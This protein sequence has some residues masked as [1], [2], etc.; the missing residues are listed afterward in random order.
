MSQRDERQKAIEQ[1]RKLRD[2][3]N[4][5]GS[6]EAEI[7]FSMRRMGQLMDTFD[8]TMDEVSLAAEECKS[9]E[10]SH[11]LGSVFHLGTVAVAVAKFCD[12][13]VFRREGSKVQKRDRNGNLVYGKDARGRMRPHFEKPVYT[14]VFHGIESDAETA[15][16]LME[17]IRNSVVKML[18]DY[19]KTGEYKGYDGSKTV[20]TKSFVDGFA[21]RIVRRLE[22]LK[23][24][25]EE[26]IERARQAR[27]EDGEDQRSLDAEAAAH[28]RR[29]GNSTDLVALKDQKVKDSFKAKYGWTVKYRTG[30]RSGG[31]S[32]T[33]RA[34]GHSAANNVNLSRPIGNGGG[35]S[36]QR[37]L[38]HG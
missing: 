2:R 35:Y 9:V 15:A 5:Q 7:E 29:K 20:L 4:G 3:L 26:E 16:Y 17:L 22:T 19:K 30:R 28:E 33:G 18:E 14:N 21:S 6:S 10:L 23:A 27:A 12:C 25:R 36:G 24:E 1:V 8:I 11:T 13:V 34:A 32:Y 37:Q 38:S 31:G